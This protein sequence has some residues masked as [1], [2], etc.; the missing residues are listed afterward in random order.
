MANV[1][2]LLVDDDPDLADLSATYLERVRDGFDVT[3]ETNPAAALGRLA[4]ERVDCVVSDY[5]MPEM[6]GLTFL[7]AVRDD[8]PT[9][10]FVLFTGKGSEEIASE[11]ISAGVTDYLQKESGSD[12]YEV[13]AN[14]VENAVERQRAEARAAELS[15]VNDVIREVQRGLVSAE[16][17]EEVERLACERLTQSEPYVFAWVGD[18]DDDGEVRPR[19]SAGVGQSYLDA[20]QSDAVDS[21]VGCG[22]A[23]RAVQTG[24]S[25]VVD[26]LDRGEGTGEWREA[27]TAVGF[28]SVVCVP[29]VHADSSYGVLCIYADRTEAFDHREVTVLTELGETVAKAIH[30]AETRRTLAARER[31]LDFFEQVVEG[32]GVGVAAYGSDGQLAYVN[33]AFASM[34]GLERPALRDSGIWSLTPEFDR[35][36]TDDYWQSFDLGETRRREVE[37]IRS[38]GSRVPVE[39]STTCVEI[40]DD[41]Y[42]VGTISDISERTKRRAELTES[43]RRFSAVFEDP[44]SFIGLLETDG[45]VVRVNSTALSFADVTNEDVAGEQFW[46]TPWWDPYPN[47]QLRSYLEAA[48]DGEFVRFEAENSGPDETSVTLDVSIRPVTGDDGEVQSL[49]AEGRDITDRKRQ[50]R[51]LE[52]Q[53]ERLDEFASVLSHDLRNP[54]NVAQGR[55]ELGKETGDTEHLVAASDAIDRMEALVESVLE[56]ARQG[57]VVSDPDPVELTAVA[58]DARAT[59]GT[60]SGVVTIA[61]GLGTVRAD[62][63]RVRTLF[64]NLFHNAV[65]HGGSDV[66]L[67]VS[68]LE[69]DAGFYVADDGTGIPEGESDTV[70][71]RGYS[72]AADG[73]GFGLPIVQSIADSHGWSLRLCESE[74]G[75]VRVEVR[76]E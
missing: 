25:Q 41:R 50:K 37:M 5:D 30:A 70:F 1:R 40:D 42:H 31:E 64:E 55:V 67:V 76:T 28:H 23:S 3:V 6:D 19:A 24:D 4:D 17:R 14:R 62:R 18:P 36:R 11:A 27:A 47:Q 38:D 45:T 63:E 53:N 56:F 15:R 26:D 66:S 68:P 29:L 51:K 60:D 57:R 9:L 7:D 34:L 16:T 43:E 74:W 39:T 71:D 2:V 21:T 52:R 69:D 73:T 72:T 61:D 49:I 48:A 33:E 46:E 12:Q 59:A 35:E 44:S 65:E 20:I 58:D 75:G 54:L 32:V 22:P 13:L 8:H 10:P